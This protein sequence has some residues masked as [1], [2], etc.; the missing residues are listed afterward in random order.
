[1]GKNN[2][3][4]WMLERYLLQE[5][6]EIKIR[7]IEGILNKNPEIRKRADKIRISDKNI[8]RKYNPEQMTQRI[9][10]AFNNKNSRPIASKI[11]NLKR[12]LFPSFALAGVIVLFVIIFPIKENNI[13]N[14]DK[15]DT[16]DTTRIKGDERQLYIYRKK[17]YSIELL[18]NGA[19]AY[20]NDLIQ[21]AYRSVID[22]FVVIF[23]IDGRGTVTFHYP[24]NETESAMI[25]GNKKV[26]LQ[27]AY[28]L[29]DSPKFERFFLITS[30]NKPDIDKILKSANDL[31]RY[32]ER[33]LKNNLKLE[34]SMNQISITLEK[35][36]KQ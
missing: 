28:E 15:I 4:D 35:G 36:D 24:K 27:N 16:V 20:K 21:I 9:M 14:I 13:H 1:M 23:S 34:D 30:K 26:F 31:A 7:E 22:P 29:D 2:I 32:P 18:K 12:F 19:K 8:L 25:P 33:A 6:P 3:S 11:N 10:T 17:H 5:L